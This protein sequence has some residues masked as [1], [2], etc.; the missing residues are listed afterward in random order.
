MHAE[1][2]KCIQ[3]LF[4]TLEGKAHLIDLDVNERMGLISKRILRKYD[5]YWIHVAHNK[6]E[7][8]ALVNTV[9]NFRSH[10]KREF[11]KQLS[12]YQLLKKRAVNNI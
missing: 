7:W 1:D 4:G 3:H 8:R 12:G 6:V 5:V 10:K 11:P 9:M 2:E